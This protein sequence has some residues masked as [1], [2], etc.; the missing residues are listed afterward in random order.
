VAMAMQNIRQSTLQNADH[1]R[2]LE[3]SARHLKELSATLQ[4]MAERYAGGGKS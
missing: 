1:S 3:A 4:A 2:Q